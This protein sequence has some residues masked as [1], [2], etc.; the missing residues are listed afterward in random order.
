MPQGGGRVRLDIP[1]MHR[2]GVE[3]A[4]NDDGRFGKT[5]CEIAFFEDNFLTDI[6]RNF[7]GDDAHFFGEDVVV[8]HWCS[9][10]H[11]G[12]YFEYGRVNF[13]VD[14]NFLG[15]F[16]R[17]M[18]RVR[19]HRRHGLT[20]INNLIRR[21][22]VV[23][24]ILDIHRPFTE[25]DDAIS[26]MRQIGVGHNRPHARHLF[27]SRDVDLLNLRMSMGTSQNSPVNETSDLHVSPILSTPR[28]LIDPIMP[29]RARSNHFV[30]GF[31]SGGHVGGSLG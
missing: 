16:F 15:G 24:Q 31:R 7:A 1:L 25:F 23:V 22:N 9:R 20:A 26:R 12:S 29:Q 2:G 17:L 10:R 14:A 6:G 13:I 28:D 5:G 30:L 27:G 11:R 4:F 3:L 8:Q 18:N 19:R 21:Q